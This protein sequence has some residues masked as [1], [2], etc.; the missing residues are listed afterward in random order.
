M[1]KLNKCYFCMGEHNS[2]ECPV[3]QSL[4]PIYKNKVGNIMEYYIAENFKC[5]ECNH[6]SLYVLGNYT[7]SL[8]I[9]CKTC[10]EKFEVKSKCL[11]VKNLPLDINLNHGSY[12]YYINRLNEKLNLFVIIYGVNRSTKNIYIREILYANNNLLL[13][14]TII[15]VIKNNNRSIIQIKQKN[16]LRKLNFKKNTFMN[17]EELIY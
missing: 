7:P 11:S 13:N 4:S 8:D 10:L 9:I 14:S 12:N 2:R 5:P 6:K 15:N 17:F 16:F 1:N 3:E